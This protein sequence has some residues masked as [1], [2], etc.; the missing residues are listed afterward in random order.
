MTNDLEA[1]NSLLHDEYY[2]MLN[3]LGGAR[4]VTRGLRRLQ[5]TF[6]GSDYSICL[7]SSLYLA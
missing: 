5:T 7:W 3:V 4:N 2:R 6:G 1:A